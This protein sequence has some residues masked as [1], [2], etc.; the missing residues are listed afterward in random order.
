[1]RSRREVSDNETFPRSASS[2]LRKELSFGL[3]GLIGS[4]DL[5]QSSASVAAKEKTVG[6]IPDPSGCRCPHE[7]SHQRLQFACWD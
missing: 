7:S 6:S 4:L 1:M 2:R 5:F 3:S